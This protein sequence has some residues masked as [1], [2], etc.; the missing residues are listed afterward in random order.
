MFYVRVLHAETNIAWLQAESVRGRGAVSFD[1]AVVRDRAGRSDLSAPV[2]AL[3][4]PADVRGAR[5]RRAAGRH[6]RQVDRR[7]MPVREEH[8]ALNTIMSTVEE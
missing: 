6:R 1:R 7:D 5:R 2:G 4:P 3:G 8:V